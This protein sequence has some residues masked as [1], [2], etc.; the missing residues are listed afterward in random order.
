MATETTNTESL[1]KPANPFSA[2]LDNPTRFLFF[3]GKGGVGKTSLA[4]ATAVALADRGHKV[5]LVST[6]PAS[7]LDEVL[8]QKLD[9]APTPIPGADGLRALN[10]DPEAAAQAYRDRMV[11]PYRGKLPEALLRSMEEQLSGACTMEIAAFDEFARLLGEPFATADF[12]HVIFDTAPTGHTLRLMTLPTAWTGFLE[13]NTSGTS[14][15][16]PLAGLQKQR[17]IYESSVA[18]LA[19]GTRTTLVLVSRPQKAALDEAERT[20]GELSA[21]GVRNQRLILNGVFRASDS[22]T[23]GLALERRGTSALAAKQNFLKRLPV[24]E[25][26]LR[27][28][29]LVG[30]PALRKLIRNGAAEHVTVGD[31]VRDLP[32]LESLSALVDDLVRSGR[33]VIMTMGK[34]GVGKT[35][36]A[37]AIATELA[38]RGHKVNLST[39]D[40]AAHMA[41]AVG[42]AAGLQVSRI[43]PQAET[44]TYV[45]QVMATAGQGLDANGRALLEEDLRSPCT[46]EIAVFRAFARIVAQ[47]QDR[48][49]VLDTA[50]TGHTLLL[51]DATEAYHR[52]IARNASDMPEEVLQLLPR[53]RDP[54]FTRVLVVT[55]PEATPVHEAAALQDDLRR[56]QIE[57][58]AWV[59]NQSF[60]ESGSRDPLLV[61][62]GADEIPYIREVSGKFSKRTAI[63]PWVAEEPVGPD[64]LRQLFQ[65]RNRNQLR[66]I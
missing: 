1:R 65:T 15:L 4:C 57:P 20:S 66:Q 63:V 56:A 52:E 21:L 3:T 50:P 37:A 13:N 62:R 59:I 16:G 51:L 47:G 7:N 6:D 46:E 22:D 14:C 55:L 49:V 19:D 53:L 45:E 44:K 31:L 41:A 64:K 33:G 26:P 25:V 48:F 40:P 54:R 42:E 23:L 2:F 10:I 29:N 5:L 11:G 24:V 34:G 9:G 8:G 38:R 27:A 28:H 36:V 39:T 30:L 17:A 12:D 58:F 61:A 43:D 60:A 35:T 18:T 32:P